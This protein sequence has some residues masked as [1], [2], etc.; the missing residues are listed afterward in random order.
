NK[1]FLKELLDK[2]KVAT[3]KTELLLSQS[4]I[5]Y[6][7]IGERLGYPVVLKIPDGSFSIGVEKAED[8]AQF[9]KVATE[10]FNQSTILLAQ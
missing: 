8:L 2:H 6:Q 5:D 10:L 3:P 9:K 4:E 7:A 1:V